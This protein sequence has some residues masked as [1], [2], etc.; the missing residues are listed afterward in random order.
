MQDAILT[1]LSKDAIITLT[2]K[3]VTDSLCVS[4]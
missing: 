2:T 1:N 3:N 4:K